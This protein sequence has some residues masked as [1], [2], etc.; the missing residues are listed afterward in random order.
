MCCQEPPKPPDLTASAEASEEIARIN[1]Q[2]AREQLAWAREQ[3]TANR[4]ILERV[5]GT[6]LPIMEET[7]RNAQ[8]DRARYET[9]FQPIEN[10]LIQE[11]QGYA[12]PERMATERGRAIADVNAQ[13]DTQRRNAIT[14]LESYGIDPST[15][16]NQ[17]L[18]VG[19]RT[20]QA[21]ASAGA[22]DAAT[23]R[24]ENTGR[25][26]RAEAI[27]IGRGLPSQ[28]AGSYGQSIAA[29]QSG[30]GS[31]NQTSQTGAN[32]AT[33]SLGFGQQALQGYQQG[34][35]IRTQGF[36]NQLAGF[37]AAGN[38]TIG[39]IGALGSLAGGVAGFVEEGG[40]I[41]GDMSAIPGPNDNIPAMLAKD[42][43]VIPAD[44]VKY[45]GVEFLDKLI[46]KTRQAIAPPP[47]A[48]QA[49]PVGA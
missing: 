19:V 8:A 43:Y 23:Q 31:A 1:Q 7:F 48:E 42:E 34:A 30:I 5:L 11:F 10:Q 2:T 15:T 22:A 27:N 14:R 29:G 44:V 46:L 41:P 35:G 20:A 12:S 17:A 18:D 16:R 40:S 39:M 49:I 28:V 38:Q 33:S 47:Q 21:A 13:F 37:E 32:L 24:V 45:K 9:T 4:D 26:L 36:N 6:Q 3:D 25:A